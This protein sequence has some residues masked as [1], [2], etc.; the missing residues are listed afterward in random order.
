MTTTE[1]RSGFRLPWA[2]D[3]R[4]SAHAVDDV[5]SDA[6]DAPAAEDVPTGSSTSAEAAETEHAVAIS[7]PADI[8]WPEADPTAGSGDTITAPAP[9]PTRARRDNPLVAGLVRA[10]R[11]AASTARQE[12]A[13]RFAEEAKARVEALHARS[14]D[15]AAQ[16]RRHADAEIGE[17]RDW[18]KAEIARIRQETDDRVAGRRGR[19]E[20][21]LAAH[22]ARVEHRIELVQAAIA[23]FERR[24]DAFFEQLLAEEDPARLAGLAEQLPEP[25]ALDV[26]A[27]DEPDPPMTASLLDP[28]GAAAA[29][30]EAFA[31]LDRTDLAGDEGDASPADDTHD[32]RGRDVEVARRLETFTGPPTAV[33]EAI[34][35]RLTVVGLV[36][37]ASIAGFKRGLA[38]ASGVRSVTVASGP[39]GDFIF[40]VVHDPEAAVRS[41]VSA[42]ETFAPTITADADG[43]I[44]VTAVDP[45]RV[46]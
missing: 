23:D 24:M 2:S 29:E 18:S 28:L 9:A 20:V 43:V 39:T 10:M 33:P 40:T 13:A 41:A 16:L 17:I 38:R 21:E 5:P 37:V 6:A 15:E 12:A 14:V 35:T 11:D 3:P 27:V 4:P 31:D 22:A 30:A 7:D 19:L 34:T 44:A 26:D 42:L 46:Q 1:Q 45:E 36:S 25:P 8:T 32:D